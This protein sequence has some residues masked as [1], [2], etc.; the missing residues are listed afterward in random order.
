M[1]QRSTRP[2]PRWERPVAARFGAS[3]WDQAAATVDDG[4]CIG[5]DRSHGFAANAGRN[6]PAAAG[7]TQERRFCAYTRTHSPAATG[8]AHFY[9][10]MRFFAQPRV[11][12]QTIQVMI[13]RAKQRKPLA[14]SNYPPTSYS[15]GYGMSFG[16]DDQLRS[17]EPGRES[18]SP[19]SP[20]TYDRVNQL[21]GTHNVPRFQAPVAKFNLA[22]EY[23]TSTANGFKFVRGMHA[24]APSAGSPSTFRLT[25]SFGSRTSSLSTGQAMKLPDTFALD[26]DTRNLTDTY[27]MYPLKDEGGGTNSRSGLVPSS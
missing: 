4:D 10:L 27:H 18:L 24:S 8:G 26:H 20:W 12:S 14:S 22:D 17:R 2:L 3:G 19:A 6:R 21:K 16:L 13:G 5:A 15:I 23:R 1:E 11:F 7:G 9:A 25:A